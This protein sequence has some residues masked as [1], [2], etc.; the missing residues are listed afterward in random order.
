[1]VGLTGLPL[2]GI[3][4]DWDGVKLGPE[5]VVWTLVPARGKR[6]IQ[7]KYLTTLHSIQPYKVSPAS[8]CAKGLWNLP[9]ERS[10]M[11]Q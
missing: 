4:G 11:A 1:M 6:A 5:E 7:L 10:D 9:I 3:L 2:R 8:G